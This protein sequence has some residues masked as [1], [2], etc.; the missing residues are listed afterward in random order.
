MDDEELTVQVAGGGGE[1]ERLLRISR[2]RDGLVRVHE[3]SGDDWS[4]P[5]EREMPAETLLRALEE[6]ARQRR[7]LSEDLYRIRLWLVGSAS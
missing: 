1:P 4:R 5:A 3:L 7:R 6:A 2:P